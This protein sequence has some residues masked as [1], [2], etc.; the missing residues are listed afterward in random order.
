M[1]SEGMSTP[2]VRPPQELDVLVVG[3]GFAG[4][5]SLHRLREMGRSVHVVEAASDVGGVWYWNRYPGAR[6]DIE[7]VDYCYSFSDEILQEWNWTE[8]YP[9]QPEILHY[10]NFVADK[11]DLRSGITLDTRVTSLIFD[12]AASRWTAETDRGDRIVARHVIMATGQLSVAQLPGIEGRDS[13]AGE[14][15][16]T[17]NWPHEPVDFAG[18]RVGVIGT[19]SSGVQ[20]I[21]QVARQAKPIRLD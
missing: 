2:H 18:K 11:L 4:L 16:H 14:S 12:D 6:C 10:I 17:G 21:P 7:S 8:R 19:G 20:A 9:A 3:A 13:F 1:G 5:Y 15:Y